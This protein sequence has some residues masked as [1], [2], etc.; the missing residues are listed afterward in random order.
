MRQALELA[1]RGTALVSP[2]PELGRSLRT[3]L[4][5]LSAKASISF[6]SIKDVKVFTLEQAAALARGRTIYLNLQPHCHRR[7]RTTVRWA[8]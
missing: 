7:W 2:R 3:T 8:R 4:G 1:R 6:D 5:S